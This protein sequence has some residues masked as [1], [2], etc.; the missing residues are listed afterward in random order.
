M[1]ALIQING[2]PLKD[3]EKRQTS[4]GRPWTRTQGSH[5]TWQ[6]RP[7]RCRGARRAHSMSSTPWLPRT[8]PINVIRLRANRIQCS[9]S[10]S[11]KVVSGRTLARAQPSIEEQRLGD[12]Q[13]QGEQQ[14]HR[15]HRIH[16]YSTERKRSHKSSRTT[17]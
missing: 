13:H 16:Q 4:P 5:D 17:M 3:E 9:R 6:N 10:M 14:P 8:A 11:P 2:H 12:E 1:D 15:H 7:G